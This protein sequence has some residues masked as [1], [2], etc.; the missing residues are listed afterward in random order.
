MLGL[1]AAT[2]FTDQIPIH[3]Q[4]TVFSLA[5]IIAG[6]YRSLRQLITQIKQLHIDEDENSQVETVSNS[7]ALQ[8]PLF[9]GGM[10]VGLYTMIKFLGKESV[11]Y[12]ILAYLAVGSTTGIKALL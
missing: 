5:I 6:S 2:Y 12:F 3:L 7:D 9:A 1:T 4:I 10:L 8:F 11:N